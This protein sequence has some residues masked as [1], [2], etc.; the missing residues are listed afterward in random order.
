MIVFPITY[1]E[2]SCVQYSGL[3]HRT[4]LHRFEVLDFIDD[5][6][7]AYTKDGLQNSINNE[8]ANLD[9]NN[10]LR[11]YLV[12]GKIGQ[13]KNMLACIFSLR[14]SSMHF[15]DNTKKNGFNE[16]VPAVE[17]VYLAIDKNFREKCPETKGLGVLVFDA[18]I[19]PVVQE[20]ASLA[21][22]TY[23]FLF[24][25]NNKKL[26]QYYIHN[27]DFDELPPDFEKSV[28]E[29]LGTEYNKDCKFLYQYI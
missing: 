5:D 11:T 14:C 9:D 16:I 20:I 19:T 23:L 10:H 13:D 28:V 7:N 21:G 22:A 25:I 18:F 26:T 8:V 17:L 4:A 24:A 2:F 6:G 29:N 12:Y 27:M 3:D 15:Q 1:K